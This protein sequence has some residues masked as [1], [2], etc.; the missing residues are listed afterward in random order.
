MAAPRDYYEILGVSRSAGDEEIRS[1]HR[2]LARQFHPDLNKDPAA[3]ERFN[4]IQQAYE[5]LKDPEKRRKYDRFGHAGLEAEMGAGPGGSGGASWQEM[6]PDAMRDIFGDIFGDAF[7]GG[8]G[9]SGS[10]SRRRTRSRA[11]RPVQGPD[12]E[13]DLTIGFAV[14]A[15]GGSEQL[16]LRGPDGATE[17]IDVRIP[18]GVA[19]GTRLRVRGRGEPGVHGGPRGDLIL[20]VRVG[21]HPWFERDGLDLSIKVPITIAEAALGAS[22]EV[23]LLVGRATLK[24]PAGTSGGSRLRLR[25]KGIVDAKGNAGDLHV[26]LSIAAPKELAPEDREALESMANRLPDPRAGAPWA[27]A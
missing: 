2:R 19:D 8:G 12:R 11:P 21:G 22:I 18:A 17:T 26:L 1:A 14:A 23:P 13:H 20:T 10:G 3:G 25:G 15:K 27:D 5:V 7:G 6:D 16:R 9:G 24:V 4:E